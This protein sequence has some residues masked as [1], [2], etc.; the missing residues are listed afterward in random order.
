MILTQCL[1]DIS[2]DVLAFSAQ[3]L[4]EPQATAFTSLFH[5]EGGKKKR[6]LLTMFAWSPKCFSVKS[7]P[8]MFAYISLTLANMIFE[9]NNFAPGHFAIPSEIEILLRKQ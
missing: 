9:K 3:L 4:M 8:T 5:L 1:K 2:P 7:C 6:L